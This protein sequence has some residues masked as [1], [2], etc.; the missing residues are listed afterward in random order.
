M[1]S[2]INGARTRRIPGFAIVTSAIIVAVLGTAGTS[3]YTIVPPPHL[4]VCFPR[5]VFPLRH[6]SRMFPRGGRTSTNGDRHGRTPGLHRGL[7]TF[8]SRTMA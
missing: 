4:H 6:L 1:N 7:D 3:A 2:T 8:S 5:C